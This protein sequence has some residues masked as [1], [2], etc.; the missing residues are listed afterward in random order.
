MGKSGYNDETLI[1]SDEKSP[2]CNECGTESLNVELSDKASYENYSKGVSFTTLGDKVKLIYDGQLVKN[3]ASGVFAVVNT[4]DGKSGQSSSTYPMNSTNQ[5]YYEL[6]IPAQRYSQINV[7]FKDNSN[8]WDDN[9]GKN[10]S[11]Y[12]Q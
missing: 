8:N 4:V 5:Q 3:G 11:Y 7:S 6:T 9:S 1:Y 10:Y 2:G 12:N